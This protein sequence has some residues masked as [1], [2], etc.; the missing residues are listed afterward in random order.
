M[1]IPYENVDFLRAYFYLPLFCFVLHRKMCSHVINI[2]IYLDGGIIKCKGQQHFV[3]NYGRSIIKYD[4]TE[5]SM[6]FE[7]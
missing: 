6:R 3:T 4:Y 1:P 5:I 2:I 7:F